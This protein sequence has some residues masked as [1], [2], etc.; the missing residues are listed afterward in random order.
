MTDPKHDK[1]EVAVYKAVH[2]RVL[3][4]GEAI[5]FCHT[6]RKHPTATDAAYAARIALALNCLPAFDK[7]VDALENSISALK[8]EHDPKRCTYCMYDLRCEVV[9]Q[10]KESDAAL[11]LA[12]ECGGGQ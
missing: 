4:G 8:K 7:M 3:K 11:A 2:T 12:K 9:W 1:V 10:I 5:C 6:P